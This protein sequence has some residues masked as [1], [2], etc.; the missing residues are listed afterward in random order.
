[1]S[2]KLEDHVICIDQVDHHE[3]EDYAADL[4]SHNFENDLQTAQSSNMTESDFFINSE[5]VFTNIN[6]E[7]CDSLILV[8][9][10]LHSL[11]LN[12]E[13]AS[14]HQ[15]HVSDHSDVSSTH[16]KNFESVLSFARTTS[17]NIRNS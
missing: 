10:D 9:N 3:R 11:V 17:S 5:F 2:S 14:M 1:M 15:S 8:I 16:M 13:T 7:R 6:E 4:R 12:A